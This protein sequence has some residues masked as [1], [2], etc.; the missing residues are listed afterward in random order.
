MEK[1]N[2][3]Y[4]YELPLSNNEELTAIVGRDGRAVFDYVDTN[5]DERFAA[6]LTAKLNGSADIHSPRCSR[7]RTRASPMAVDASS[8]YGGGGGSLMCAASP[9]AMRRRSS[10]GLLSGAWSG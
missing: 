2:N 7:C 8:T 3:L 1:I 9:D 10:S 6:S 5:V 4:L